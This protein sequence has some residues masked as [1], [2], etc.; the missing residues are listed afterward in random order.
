MHEICI[1]ERNAVGD[2]FPRAL[3]HAEQSDQIAVFQQRDRCYAEALLFYQP[4]Q[5]ISALE[6]QYP[7]KMRR[8]RDVIEQLRRRR[9]DQAK[10][11]PGPVSISDCPCVQKLRQLVYLFLRQ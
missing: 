8:A 2:A 6:E 5:T 3:H 11:R 10:L 7:S 1:L 9:N 4:L